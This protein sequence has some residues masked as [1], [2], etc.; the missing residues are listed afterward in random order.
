MIE[1]SYDAIDLVEWYYVLTHSF[2]FDSKRP[3][4]HLEHV[5]P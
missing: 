4:T 2:T 3:F 1:A 5:T